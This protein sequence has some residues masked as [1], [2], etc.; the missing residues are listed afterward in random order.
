MA[1]SRL[2]SHEQRLDVAIGGTCGVRTAGGL[3][4]SRTSAARILKRSA[5]DIDQIL[6]RVKYR[7]QHKQ[8]ADL[9]LLRDQSRQAPVEGMLG[10]LASASCGGRNS[11]D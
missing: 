11:P 3:L 7:I 8:S 9:L 10:P 6:E 5:E 4:H 1:G 2:S